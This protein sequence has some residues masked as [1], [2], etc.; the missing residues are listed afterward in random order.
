MRGSQQREM[1]IVNDKMMPATIGRRKYLKYLGLT[2]AGIAMGAA[3]G[4]ASRDVE[5]LHGST[6]ASCVTQKTTLTETITGTVTE[7]TTDRENSSSLRAAGDQRGI[8]VG[9]ASFPE[10]FEDA[11]YAHTL[12]REFNYLTP[13][14]QMKW[15]PIDAHGYGSADSLVQF[16]SEHQMK[17]KGHTL[18]WHESLPTWVNE[19][20]SASELRNALEA[21]ISTLVGRYRGRVLAWDVVNEAVDDKQG[22]RRTLFLEKLGE[23]YIAEAFQLAHKA[24][25][26]AL[27]IYNDYGAEGLNQKSDRVFS[28]VSKL[29]A[30]GVPI[31]GVGL[32][33]HIS[34]GG[35]PRP[36]DVAS[37]VRRLSALGLGAYIS[38]MDV[39]IGDVPG[40]LPE[41][42]Q[43][44]RRVYHDVV[45]PCLKEKSFV[46][47]TFWG[48]T[49]ARSTTGAYPYLFD[50]NY[51]PKPAYWGVLGALTE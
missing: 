43:L 33:M 36:E 3:L 14:D 50:E 22:L 19:Q 45:A 29:V 16:A 26:D 38:E 13:E 42:L 46:A 41:R 15:G 4:Y 47:L 11:R 7:T 51:Y 1:R 2:A 25:P 24:D 49:D 10:G 21:H 5:D 30:D 32:Q 20:M 34:A 12:A 40:S 37:N 27:L 23:G 18:V 31:H 6:S 39:R 17:I 9:A 28:L 48:I 44:Q 8:L 35:Y